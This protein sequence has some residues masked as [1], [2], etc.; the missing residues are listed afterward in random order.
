MPRITGRNLAVLIEMGKV[1]YP[2]VALTSVSSP[3]DKVNKKFK[4][5]DILSPDDNYP[6]S[7]YLDGI[8]NG[9]DISPTENA[10][11]VSI[12]ST[13]Y[14]IKGEEKTIVSATVSNLSRPTQT[15]YIVWNAIC[16]DED[17]VGSD[18][19]NCPEVYNPDQI[20]SDSDGIGDLC[21]NAPGIVITNQTK[22]K[23]T[24]RKKQIYCYA[25]WGTLPHHRLS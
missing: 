18:T 9:G 23:K 3:A 19:D 14:Y 6:V 7:V 21:D 2:N 25:W 13:T 8:I 4:C 16:A 24:P 5:A 1:P 22:S 17:G 12:G 15:G 10:N 20:D 11:E